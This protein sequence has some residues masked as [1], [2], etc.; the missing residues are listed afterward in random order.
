MCQWTTRQYSTRSDD[1][2][3]SSSKSRVRAQSSKSYHREYKG[4][5]FEWYGVKVVMK[6]NA[7]VVLALEP[8]G[9]DDFL[10]YGVLIW[11]T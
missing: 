9:I 1:N 3:Y 4:N 6:D 8:R 5:S 11:T 7:D 10:D 2:E